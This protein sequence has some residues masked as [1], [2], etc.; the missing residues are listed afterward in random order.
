[1]RYSSVTSRWR[2]VRQGLGEIMNTNKKFR[3]NARH[4]RAIWGTLPKPI[5]HG[6]KNLTTE[7]GLSVSSGDLQLL[8]GRWYVTHAGLLRISTSRRCS[9]IRTLIEKG[10]SNPAS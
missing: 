9:G 6:L 10:L 2:L 4:A 5:V 8:E 1:M 3:S 7:Y